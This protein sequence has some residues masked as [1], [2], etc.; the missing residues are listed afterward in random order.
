[1]LEA[2]AVVRSWFSKDLVDC[3][4]SLKR[5]EIGLMKGLSPEEAC[6]RYAGVY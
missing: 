3:Y 6:A 1:M 4:L 2:D 5:N